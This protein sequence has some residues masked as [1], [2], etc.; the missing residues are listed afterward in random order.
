MNTYPSVLQAASVRNVYERRSLTPILEPLHP[1]GD[2]NK[3]P[4]W[5]GDFPLHWPAHNNFCEILTLL[6]DAGADIEA[7][8]INCYGGKPLHWASEHAPDAVALLLRRGANV[9]SR[10]LRS[11]SQFFG[12]TLLI[13]NATQRNDCAEVTALLLAEGAEIESQDAAGKTSLDH[14][15]ARDL[16]R[17]TQALRSG[18]AAHTSKA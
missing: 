5:I 10:N 17:I 14:A 9:N 1:T 13:M 2:P 11:D 4:V 12:M 15:L 6:L 16:S 8:E 7:D 3:N 18:S